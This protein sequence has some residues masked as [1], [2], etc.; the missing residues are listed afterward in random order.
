MIVKYIDEA[1]IKKVVIESMDKPKPDY[2]SAKDEF[3]KVVATYFAEKED[4][5]KKEFQRFIKNDNKVLETRCEDDEEADGCLDWFA[6]E[7]EAYCKIFGSAEKCGGAIVSEKV[8]EFGQ[9]SLILSAL[10]IMTTMISVVLT[11]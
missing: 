5:E 2:I 7:L 6:K 9:S 4:R 11:F 10:G 3:D 1:N 8:T